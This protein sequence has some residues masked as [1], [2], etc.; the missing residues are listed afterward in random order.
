MIADKN[1][2]TPDT[3]YIKAEAT[4]EKRISQEAYEE[5]AFNALLA[6]NQKR[7]DAKATKDVMKRPAAS[8]AVLMRPAASLAAA[9]PPVLTRPAS[10]KSFIYPLAWEPGD[11][12]RSRNVFCSKHY[13]RAVGACKRA[14]LS[15]EDTKE[16]QKIALRKAGKLWD[17]SMG[18]K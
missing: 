5:S 8:V 18:L 4:D 16:H 13:R 14:G 2:T 15:E 11:E 17:E 7:K 9:A 6:R 10:S 1:E 12:K 3:I